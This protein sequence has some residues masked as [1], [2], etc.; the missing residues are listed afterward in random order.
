MDAA[1]G[2][3]FDRGET[4]HEAEAELEPAHD[5]PARRFVLTL[6]AAA[7]GMAVFVTTAVVLT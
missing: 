4:L 2:A 7:A 5:S 1:D 3:W 6:F